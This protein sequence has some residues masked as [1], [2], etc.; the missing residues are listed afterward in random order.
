MFRIQ[1]S[2]RPC[3]SSDAGFSLIEVMVAMFIFAVVS[4]AFASALLTTMQVSSDSLARQT[5]SSLAAGQI[6]QVRTITD[7]TA[8]DSSSAPTDVSVAG[9]V[10]HVSTIVRWT[11]A[12]SGTDAQCSSG[13]GPLLNKA[14]KVVVSWDGMAASSLP[15]EADTV[16]AP[17]SRISDVNKGVIIV[18][19][20][21]AQGAGNSAVAISVVPN[22][23]TP[24]GASAISGTI[25]PTDAQGCGY[26]L[27]VTPGKYDVSITKGGT[28]TPS[29]DITQS[30]SPKQ[31]VD[32]SAGATATAPFQFDQSATFIPHYASNV[33]GTVVLPLT[34]DTTFV[35]T[36][37]IFT[38]TS[39]P[40]RLH[41]FTAGYTVLAGALGVNGGTASNCLAVDPGAWPATTDSTGTWAGKRPDAVAA[42]PGGS[43][44]AYVPMGAVTVSGP[45][46]G[47]LAAA[48]QTTGPSGSGN[49]GCAVPKTYLIKL[50]ATGTA[51]IALPFGSWKMTSG[52]TAGSQTTKVTA[53]Q[54]ALVTRG[55][56]GTA[57][58]D[59]VVTLDPRQLVTP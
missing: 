42:A 41:P 34:M 21:N 56:L 28:S 23:T 37:G 31:T 4:L 43:A 57:N 33:T 59:A 25:D 45:A 27:N 7:L 49:P 30:T 35:N 26:V 15:A 22:P 51:T 19:V 29:V 39:T 44:D 11:G 12:G 47:Y 20:K 10:Y 38:T 9:R 58:G 6:D 48:A 5:A 2:P 18:S 46:N 36:Y 40:T 50:P 32:V 13:T 24:N 3:S 14:V 1:F 52:T 8:L 54:L 53:S 17:K 55:M 16:V